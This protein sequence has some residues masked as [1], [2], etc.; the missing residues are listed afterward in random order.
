MILLMVEV[1]MV[2]ILR[3]FFEGFVIYGILCMMMDL[4]GLGLIMI[5]CR[6]IRFLFFFVGCILV[7]GMIG[8]IIGLERDI[9]L[10]FW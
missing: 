9:C 8:V 2:V 5:R 4:I 10:W 1:D 6:V 7:G 3:L